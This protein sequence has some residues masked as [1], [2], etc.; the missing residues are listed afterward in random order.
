MSRPRAERTFRRS[1]RLQFLLSEGKLGKFVIDR[2]G[3]L[4]FETVPDEET[5]GGALL[6]LGHLERVVR[7]EDHGI[8]A[9]Q[10]EGNFLMTPVTLSRHLNGPKCR[11]F[12]F[13]VEFLDRGDQHVT[14]IGLAAKH[15][16][17]QPHHGR[18][19]NWLSVVI[20]GAVTG[21][22]HSRMSA[23]FRIPFF[24]RR[25]SALVHQGL[26]FRD[27]D[28]AKVNGWARLGHEIAHWIASPRGSRQESIRWRLTEPRS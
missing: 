1:R 3:E 27:T 15:G 5:E 17:E 7:A 16:R 28:P 18:S 13:D 8:A 9:V 6:S 11:R 26:E 2:S 14:A 12:H 19:A 25:Q 23:T 24:D 21:N 22:S 20:P 10:R 4:G